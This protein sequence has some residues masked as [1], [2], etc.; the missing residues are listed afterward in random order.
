MEIC[1]YI[2]SHIDIYYNHTQV[3]MCVHVYRYIYIYEYVY[4]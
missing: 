3:Y 4:I 1:E 2:Q